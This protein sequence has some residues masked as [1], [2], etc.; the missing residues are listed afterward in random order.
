M[1]AAVARSEVAMED[2][3]IRTDGLTKRFGAFEALSGL[4][5]V[6]ERVAILR[7]GRLVETGTLA[8]L[9]HLAAL[10]VEVTL[11]G[12]VPDLSGI[13]GVSHLRVDGNRLQCQVL[14]P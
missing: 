3:A 2:E 13:P 8:E 10:S 14:G 9:R 1:R 12:P 5:L 7:A 6:V 11:S 4:D